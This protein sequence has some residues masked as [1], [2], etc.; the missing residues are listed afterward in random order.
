MIVR[1]R[2]LPFRH[3]RDRASRLVC[4][5]V[6]GAGVLLVALWNPVTH[7]GPVLCTCRLLFGIPCPLC[8]G[9][10]GAA[11]CLR[12]HLADGLAYNPLSLPA[13]LLAFA[14][15]ARWSAEYLGGRQLVIDRPR[16]LRWT[17]LALTLAALAGTW[18]YLLCCRREDDFAASLLGR[19][20]A[21]QP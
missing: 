9:T 10:R 15:I 5:A 8:G 7:P 20:I 14:L 4:I 18:I 19:L 6:V 16:W 17:T 21:W 3:Q 12:G 13:L 2:F 1:P 11:L